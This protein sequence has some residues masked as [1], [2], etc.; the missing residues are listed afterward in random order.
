VLL[1]Q[2]FA[3]SAILEIVHNL[4][5]DVLLLSQHRGSLLE[6]RTIGSVTQFLLYNC[7]CDLILVP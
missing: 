5:P 6:Q 1:E 4:R 7:P 2:G 3:A